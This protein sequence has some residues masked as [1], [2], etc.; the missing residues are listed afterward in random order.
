VGLSRLELLQKLGVAPRA[1]M[2]DRLLEAGYRSHSEREWRQ[3]L[4]RSP[5]GALWHTSFHASSFPGDDPKAC[6]R[7][8]LYTLMGL[9]RVAPIDRRGRTIMDAGKDLEVQQV[10]RLHHL[11]VL[12]SEPPW[13]PT[14]TG[15]VL[16]DYWLTGNVD[17]VVL[18]DG[19]TTP[20]VV[21]IKGKD[22]E[23]VQKM[24][25]HEQSYDPAHRH[26]LLTYIGM[27]HDLTPQIWPLLYPAR[28]G[29]LLYVSRNRPY[30]TMEYPF[31]HD[32]GFMRAG[33][34]RLQE[35]KGMYIAN[36]LPPRD[37]SWRW[38]EPPCKWCQWKK[39]CKADIKKDVDKLHDS[40]AI[41]AARAFL[42][43]YDYERTR[44][45]VFDR[46]YNVTSQQQ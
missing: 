31:E 9:P 17:A 8:E 5:H 46:W 40:T 4:D 26:Q 25:R 19:Y 18:P 36:D 7:K 37:R 15:F 23:A 43:T 34:R 44:H 1:R 2:I 39:I 29:T 3:D 28:D 13:S 12:I 14:Q 32:P 45:A 20:H 10:M 11:G 16:P 38:T 41:P 30:N 35:W 21:E 24:W 22:D 42:P 33:Y 6:G 27:A